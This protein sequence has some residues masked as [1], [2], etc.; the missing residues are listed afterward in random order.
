MTITEHGILFTDPMALAVEEDRKPVTRR[1]SDRWEKVKPGDLLWVRQC[2]RLTPHGVEVRAKPLDHRPYRPW[3]P[4]GRLIEK[5]GWVYV[6]GLGWHWPHDKPQPWKPGI[7][8]PR[9]A[10][11]TT[12]EVVSV[13]REP[14][15]ARVASPTGWRQVLVPG[16]DDAEA[17][18][19]G[20]EDRAGFLETWHRINGFDAPDHIWRIEFRRLE[21]T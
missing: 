6:D 15:S 19:E 18:L 3:V 4:Y 2:F 11:R 7:H 12:L 10:S 9:W 20:F 16:V 8:M 5:A 17:R 1:T 21:T 14:G 13:T